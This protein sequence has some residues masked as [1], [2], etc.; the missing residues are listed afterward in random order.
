MTGNYNGCLWVTKGYCDMDPDS[1]ECYECTAPY[2]D[3]PVS[4]LCTHM[5]A[6]ADHPV[7]SAHDVCHFC[8]HHTLYDIYIYIYI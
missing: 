8:I 3:E 5:H 1:L 7:N 6:D 2:V 4:G